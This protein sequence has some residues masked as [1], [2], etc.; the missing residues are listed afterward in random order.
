MIFQ[1][2]ISLVTGA[3][4][5]IGESI[6][7]ELAREGATVV[8]VDVQKAKLEAV[9]QAIA[10]E[11]GR[12]DLY[13]ADV[14][15][16]GQAAAVVEAVLKA[17]G[18]IDHLVNNAGIT[19]D[20]LFMRMKEEEWDAVIG[21]NLKGVFNFTKAVIRS[22][23]SAR[24]GRIVN[25]SSV[26]GLMG[27]AGQTNYAASKAGLIGFTKALARETASRSITVNCVAPGYIATPMTLNLPDAVK[28]WFIDI[29]PM[30]RFGEPADVARAVRF[31][32]SDD[33]AYITGQVINV[34]GG[35]YM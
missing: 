23:I 2:R 21:V 13:E 16:S 27:N 4:Q 6:A 33:A 34:N 7:R 8:L 20:N 9:A 18:R 22:M 5:G 35:M 29:I 25:L 15:K 30:G 12:A 1:D 24:Y 11:G 17:R 19:R 32:C 31:L 28:K 10:A 26:V 3:S 14:T